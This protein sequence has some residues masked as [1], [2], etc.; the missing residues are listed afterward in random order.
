MIYMI[1]REDEEWLDLP[2]YEGLYRVNN[3]GDVSDYSGNLIKN[4]LINNDYILYTLI[5]KDG[6]KH[7][8]TGHK[9]TALAFVPNP[10]NLPIINHKNEIKQDN[11]YKNLE[12]CTRY[13][14]NHYNDINKKI[15]RFI[16][17]N[18]GKSCFIY[19]CDGNEA[20]FESHR[21]CARFLKTTSGNTASILNNPLN[22]GKAEDL[23]GG[24]CK[25]MLL[26]NKKLSIE[27]VISYFNSHLYY[28]NN[29]R[30]NNKLSKKVG[31]YDLN[32]NLIKL[33]PSVHEACRALHKT[34]SSSIASCCRG[35]LQTVYGFIWKYL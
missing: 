20:T 25:G 2:N 24:Y 19:D 18:Y 22:I 15:S 9:A 29:S 1:D 26:S 14:N 28:K 10:N 27:Q 3:Y 11:Y 8:V 12:W 4:Y 35:E 7:M 32:N 33:Y 5:G 31:Q 6:K 16:I 34:S 13:Y 17:E 21:E 23:L 30:K